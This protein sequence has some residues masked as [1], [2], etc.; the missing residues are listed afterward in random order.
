MDGVAADAVLH[1]GA[2]DGDGLGEEAHCALRRAVG[3]EVGGATQAG[4]GRDVDDG[5]GLPSSHERQRRLHAEEDAVDVDGHLAAPVFER[6]FVDKAGDG[7]AGIV[8]ED[9]EAAFGALRRC[10]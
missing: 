5:A 4:D 9:V 1:R 7:D 10:R 2:F 3:G 8:D 6:E